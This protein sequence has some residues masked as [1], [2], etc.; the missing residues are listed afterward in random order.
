M[1]EFFAVAQKGCS[2]MCRYDRKCLQY[3]DLM[4]RG[5]DLE[6]FFGVD[7]DQPSNAK[8]KKR[9]GNIKSIYDSLAT[10]DV[11]FRKKCFII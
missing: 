7:H 5:E 6:K 9:A 11:R 4:R 8:A 10:Y 1:N 3:V 2:S